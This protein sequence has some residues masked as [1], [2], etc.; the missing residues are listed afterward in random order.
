MVSTRTTAPS[1]EK[2]EGLQNCGNN[3]ANFGF[4]T[5]NLQ[6]AAATP[7]ACLAKTPSSQQWISSFSSDNTMWVTASG[8]AE[9]P[10]QLLVANAKTGAVTLDINI[11]HLG[12]LLHAK[13]NLFDVL[14]INFAD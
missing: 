7:I 5:V 1:D 4:A 11:D 12:G 10:S 2:K 6:T 8:N 14:A 3:S 13:D 9:G